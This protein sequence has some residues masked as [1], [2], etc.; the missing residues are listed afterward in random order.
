[1]HNSRTE[2]DGYEV[3]ITTSD[4][5]EPAIVVIAVRAEEGEPCGFESVTFDEIE[6]AVMLRNALDSWIRQQRG[7]SVDEAIA[8]VIVTPQCEDLPGL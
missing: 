6:T 4:A 1:M 8:S 5:G 2:N 3:S 7:V